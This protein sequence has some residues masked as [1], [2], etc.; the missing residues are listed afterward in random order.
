MLKAQLKNNLFHIESGHSYHVSLWLK[1]SQNIDVQLILI[2]NNTPWTWLG[3]KT[4]TLSSSYQL[5]DLYVNSAPFTTDDDVRFAIR[6]GN[7]IADIYVDDVVITDCTSPIN[8]YSLHT[9][10]TGKGTV[11]INHALG[12]KIVLKLVMTNF[13]TER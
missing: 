9:S 4:V 13:K 6:C 1:A 3:A 12:F 2:Q 8:Y 10:V 5:F 11:N 7:A